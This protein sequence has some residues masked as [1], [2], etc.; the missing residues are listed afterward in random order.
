ML[1]RLDHI[2]E[3]GSEDETVTIRHSLSCLV[4]CFRMAL[5]TFPDVGDAGVSLCVSVRFESFLVWLVS[6]VL[7]TG[8][9]SLGEQYLWIGFAD[10]GLIRRVP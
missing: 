5:F 10:N 3:I 7:C 1:P 6:E 9:G 8:L 2:A 4:F